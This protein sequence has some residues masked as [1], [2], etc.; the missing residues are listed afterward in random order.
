MT[1]TTHRLA[2][3]ADQVSQHKATA[4]LL[5]AGDDILYALG[6]TPPSD[7]RVTFLVV[8]KSGASL[9]VPGVNATDA[10][11][12]LAS[13]PLTLYDYADDRGP[14]AALRQAL[15]TAA[16]QEAGGVLLVSDAARHDHVKKIEG[17]L[18]P[19]R[20]ELASTVMRPLRM[21][22]DADEIARLREASRVADQAF[23]E[24]VQGIR[25]GVTERAIHDLILQV[26][27]SE[28]GDGPSFQ[29]V[30][31]G[32]NSAAPH[33]Q[34][35]ETRIGPGALWMDIGCRKN[36]YWSDLTRPVYL[37]TPDQLYANIHRIVAEARLAGEKAARV[38]R[39]ASDVDLA[40]RRV[41]EDAGY[42]AYFVHRTG[43]GIGVSG[44]EPPFMMAG[45][46]T[47]LEPGMAFSIEPGI[48]LPGQFGV[49]IEDIAVMTDDGPEILSTLPTDPVIIRD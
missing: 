6:Y 49:R 4:A 30:A 33:H 36:G 2:R 43:H 9:V 31:Y 12:R 27:R 22:K 37:G 41:I 38:G 25:P 18:S 16:G 48:Y 8:G 10:R 3:I 40:A 32:A 47:I 24:G 35:D 29:A 28:G 11:E 13:Y 34:P 23:R 46:D 7:E 26:F 15:H 17:A 20:V 42:G 14:Q 1:A 45:D 19:N 44:H 39:P 5:A 21:V